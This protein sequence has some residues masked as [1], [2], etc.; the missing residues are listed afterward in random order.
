MFQ[1]KEGSELE[2]LLKTN[3]VTQKIQ[4]IGW[5]GGNLI[6]SQRSPQNKDELLVV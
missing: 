6:G 1:E 4:S 5:G 3:N 2:F